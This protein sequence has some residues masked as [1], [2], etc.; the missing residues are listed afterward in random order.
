MAYSVDDGDF[1]IDYE[2]S[3]VDDGDFYHSD[4]I[5]YEGSDEDGGEDSFTRKPSYSILKEEDI[6][7]L[8]EDDI[9]K[10][11]STLSLRR[12]D[13]CV[14]LLAYSW[15]V[16]KVPEEWFADEEKVRKAVGLLPESQTSPIRFSKREKFRCEICGDEY[17]L[18]ESTA[19]SCGCGHAFCIACFKSWIQS[20]I[21]DGPGCLFK[22]RCPWV[23]CNAAVVAETV[24]SVAD[25]EDITKYRHYLLRSYVEQNRMIK[26][27]TGPGCDFAV[28]FDTWNADY[29]DVVCECSHTFCW[30]CSEDNHRP[31]DCGTVAKWMMKN[32]SEAENT[33][34]LLSHS[35]LCPKCKRPI[36]KNHGCMHMTCIAPCFYEFCWLCLG[37]WGEHDCNRYKREREDKDKDEVTRREKAKKMWG[38]Y[39]HHYE[40]WEGNERSRKKAVEDLRRSRGEDI[41]KLSKIQSESL[42]QVKFLVEAWEQIVECRRVLKW[43]YA[44]GYYLPEEAAARKQLF[45]YSQGEAEGVL[46]K[47][48][49]CAEREVEDYLSSAKPSE[50]FQ[51][52]RRKLCNLTSVTKGFFEK[53]VA[54][55]E[56]NPLES[57]DNV[58]DVADANK[59]LKQ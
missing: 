19:A 53:L 32:V 28:K 42:S 45:E 30:N 2:D 43:T 15:S 12:G 5:D 1:N 22:L 25:E 34:W 36:E 7:V 26:W 46:E 54:E 14:L 18:S 21:K 37:G 6:R 10:V 55:L 16:S 31:V 48:H 23:G 57:E 8:L 29:Y 56:N 41:Q 27:C 4:N 51:N 3:D 33:N 58:V 24:E 49:H 39:I 50:E 35:K 13:A 11:S 20:L 38:K 52:F 47:L 59:R 9:N 17:P 40:R 44:Y